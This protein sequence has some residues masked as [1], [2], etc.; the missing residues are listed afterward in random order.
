MVA[1]VAAFVSV[2]LR[3]RVDEGVE[4]RREDPILA[5]LQARKQAKYREIRDAEQAATIT[6]RNFSG[7]TFAPGEIISVEVR[8]QVEFSGLGFAGF[9]GSGSNF[10]TRPAKQSAR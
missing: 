9:P 6:H 10:C 3:R 2:P 7:G 8:C 1:V 5:D 4:D